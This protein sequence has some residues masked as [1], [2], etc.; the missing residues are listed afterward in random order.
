LRQRALSAVPWAHAVR[1]VNRD[2][3]VGWLIAMAGIATGDAVAV[4]GGVAVVTVVIVR[5]FL[6]LERTEGDSSGKDW[7]SRRP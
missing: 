3:F 6:V 5:G 1:G 4:F 7:L 2:R